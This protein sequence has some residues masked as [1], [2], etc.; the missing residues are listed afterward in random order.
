MLLL[1]MQWR[2]VYKG[3]PRSGD[4]VSAQSFQTK[5][6]TRLEKFVLFFCIIFL[7]VVCLHTPADRP[8]KL[9]NLNIMVCKQVF[10]GSIY[11]R[12]FKL[13]VTW[14]W[15]VATSEWRGHREM[16]A[17]SLGTRLLC[18]SFCR[19]SWSNFRDPDFGY[20]LQSCWSWCDCLFSK[21]NLILNQNRYLPVC[22]IS[23][24][25]APSPRVHLRHVPRSAIL[26]YQIFLATF[27]TD[28]FAAPKFVPSPTRKA[29]GLLFDLFVGKL[30]RKASLQAASLI[31]GG[32]W[33]FVSWKPWEL[34]RS[35]ERSE[36]S[37]E[38]IGQPL[39]EAGPNRTLFRLLQCLE[40]SNSLHDRLIVRD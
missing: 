31:V 14:D 21:S 39:T 32:L 24:S 38:R 22:T 30:H 15:S 16:P 18:K 27:V 13:G 11:L 4:S 37:L 34:F 7:C 1:L 12:A 5:K 35:C 26:S 6:M 25:G 3:T 17:I 10:W 36:A 9:W 29:L 40:W 33:V 8:C 23:F 2:E 28:D 20:S 19:L